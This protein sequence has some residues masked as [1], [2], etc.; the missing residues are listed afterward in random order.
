ML[1]ACSAC[2]D[3]LEFM[4]HESILAKKDALHSSKAF[5]QTMGGVGLAVSIDNILEAMIAET[6]GRFESICNQHYNP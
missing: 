6:K 2:L 4:T 3:S 1:E 5:M